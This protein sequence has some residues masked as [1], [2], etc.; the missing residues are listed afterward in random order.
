M[1]T[2]RALCG[3]FGISP[4]KR[5][6]VEVNLS[7]GLVPNAANAP[8]TSRV[9]G[10][11]LLAQRVVTDEGSLPTNGRAFLHLVVRVI[12]WGVRS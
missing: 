11:K 3:R 10:R 7:A 4:E 9:I 1:V 2:S 5:P 6:A 8:K 12:A